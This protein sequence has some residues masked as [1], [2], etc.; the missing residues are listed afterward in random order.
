[1]AWKRGGCVGSR[2]T[3]LSS[4][5]KGTFSIRTDPLRLA[6]GRML[7]N[8]GFWVVDE[9]VSG[10]TF[11]EDFEAISNFAFKTLQQSLLQR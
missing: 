4:Q 5:R 1:M 7:E 10:V 8:L 9:L 3:P 11:R 6:L 2:G